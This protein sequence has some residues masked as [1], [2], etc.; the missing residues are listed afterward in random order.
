MTLLA[1]LAS[2]AEWVTLQN[3]EYSIVRYRRCLTDG[4]VKIESWRRTGPQPSIVTLD[5]TLDDLRRI[6]NE[7]R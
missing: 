2:G 5:I 7:Q 6:V 4:V 3:N 1:V